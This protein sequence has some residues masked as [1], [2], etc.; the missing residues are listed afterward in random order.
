MQ[1]VAAANDLL[2]DA[3]LSGST[4]VTLVSLFFLSLL[5]IFVL[6]PFSVIAFPLLPVAVI[7][8][9]YFLKL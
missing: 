4:E 2:A 7:A 1:H 6:L 9:P 5:S 8:F 3:S